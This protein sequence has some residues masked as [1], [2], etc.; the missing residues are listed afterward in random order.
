MGDRTASF[1]AT[2][3]PFLTQAVCPSERGGRLAKFI[4]LVVAIAAG[5]RATSARY[6]SIIS[7]S[8]LGGVPGVEGYGRGSAHVRF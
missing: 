8:L 2:A 4:A 7:I 6:P 3:R 5:G 1:L